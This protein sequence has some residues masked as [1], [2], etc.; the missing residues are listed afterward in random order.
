MALSL[1]V[2]EEARADLGGVHLGIYGLPPGVL[3]RVA[4]FEATTCQVGA[5]RSLA[6]CEGYRKDCPGMRFRNII[7]RR[8]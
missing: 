2:R 6:T 5:S 3:K 7:G 1:E 4:T 8:R